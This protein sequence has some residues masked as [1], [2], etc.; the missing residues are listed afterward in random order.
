M[1]V[2]QY[3]PSVHG[4]S[5]E[6]PEDRPSA[7]V[8]V[9]PPPEPAQSEGPVA[10]V[11]VQDAVRRSVARSPQAV[12]EE[13]TAA[14]FEY[15]REC[16]AREDELEH[17]IDPDE[18]P[19]GRWAM[20]P[21]GA[22]ELIS[23]AESA[24]EIP[25]GAAG[26]LD[27]ARGGRLRYGYPLVVL[28]ARDAAEPD[29]HL[30]AGGAPPEPAD[31]P[32][33]AAPLF[34]A[35]ARA[36]PAAAG[37]R[38]RI[39]LSA[40]PEVN[41]ALLRFLGIDTAQEFAAFRRLLRGPD[42]PGLRET[43]LA[44]LA[45]LHIDRVDDVNPELLRGP[46]PLADL[47]PGAHNTALLF[48]AGFGAEPGTGD[49]GSHP[50]R[51]GVIADL[52]PGRKDAVHP[53]RIA[54]TALGA[55]FGEAGRVRDEP[56]LPV[57]ADLL[58]EER[59][60]VLDAAMRRTLTVV[61]APPG[62]GAGRLVD[63]AVRTARADGQ[64]VLVAVPEDRLPPFPGAGPG[65]GPGAPVMRAGGPGARAVEAAVLTRLAEPAGETPDHV[66]RRRSLRDDWA[67]VREAWRAIDAAASGGHAL[68][69][70]AAERRR[71]AEQGWDPG[72]L[73]GAADREPGYWLRRARRAREGGFTAL[74]HR[75]AIRRD[76]GV[77]PTEENLDRL[78][79]AAALEGEWRTALDR[80]GRTAPLPELLSGLD[81][82]LAC[83]LLSGA[84][85]LEAAE[86]RRTARGR[87][88]ITDRL[89]A[90]NRPDDPWGG[91]ARLLA[92]V[93]AWS[94][95]VRRARALPPAPGLFDL[96][97]VAEAERLSTAELIPL[98]YRAK[99][100]LV[101]GDPAAPARAAALD[102]EEERALR[103]RAG[104]PADRPP[105]WG[106][107]AGSAY[108]A[109]AAAAEK[110]GG[111]VHR[112]DGQEGVH[113]E[114]TGLAA[115][116][117]YGGRLHAL[118]DPEELPV[119]SGPAVEWRHAPGEC[120]P[121]PGGSAVNRDEAYR[122]AVLLQQLDGSLPAGARIGVIAPFQAQWA[123]LRRLLRRRTFAHEVRVGG[124]EHFRIAGRGEGPWGALDGGAV[125]VMVV[126]ATGVPTGW[127]PSPDDAP[128]RAWAAALTRT[129]ARLIVVG[130]RMHWSG[131]DGTG[132]MLCRAAS[133]EE[134]A[135]GAAG[136]AP[137]AGG[138]AS[139]ALRALL[140]A[141]RARGAEAEPHPRVAGYRADLR[142]STPGGTLL[143][144]V[145]QARTGTGLRRLLHL[146][147]LLE[148]R[149]G[150]QVVCVPAWRCLSDPDSTAAEILAGAG[151]E[152]RSPRGG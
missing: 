114:I 57:A 24:V 152:G 27:G 69:L 76:L 125:D 138:P 143:V 100:A 135:P 119:R 101:I 8:R 129:R 35:D 107:A 106:S 3:D 23:G 34:V 60:G 12:A 149:S 20:L 47:R 142:V 148:R 105:R 83:H 146:G 50:G 70:L 25:P 16:L 137:G 52:D 144:L 55:L 53:G 124:A 128:S 48:R 44:V 139:P 126:S 33:R 58:D 86:E 36:A 4:R 98:L 131:Q 51:T 110:A 26:P 84:A 140:P 113:P 109:C 14:L 104:L 94:V 93:P 41:P 118:A 127:R 116:H 132:G 17:L 99:R 31:R 15:Y 6:R 2:P 112:L 75:S 150:D 134:A 81:A 18:P 90:L 45:R 40:P 11:A 92:A 115:R 46:V 22:E 122:V 61:A 39:R 117:C 21:G 87:S 121:V 65:G 108:R 37:G 49:R 32:L 77:E 13:R 62:T 103:E 59:H 85:H 28:A 43:A 89:E 74:A 145:D 91:F 95:A 97:V 5:R 151:R 10:A 68:A 30:P 79:R 56:V 9:L 88:A 82:A 141:L 78:C 66:A 96:V 80:R 64:S 1:A 42:L 63:A 123:L 111:A 7:A 29:E 130:D 102:P 38:P 19:A 136:A 73:F 120:E 147:R 72:A 54:A 71:L 67:R 133:A